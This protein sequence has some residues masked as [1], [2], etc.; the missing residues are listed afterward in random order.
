M[1]YQNYKIFN[2]S[3]ECNYQP[4]KNES[5]TCLYILSLKI[6]KMIMEY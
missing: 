1:C 5:E 6:L 2:K 4:E 3:M